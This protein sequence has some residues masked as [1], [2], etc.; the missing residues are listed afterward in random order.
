M[1]LNICLLLFSVEI[2]KVMDNIVWMLL[3]FRVVRSCLNFISD[4]FEKCFFEKILFVFSQGIAGYF[5]KTDS[6]KPTL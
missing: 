3:V 6:K 5:Q 2:Y 1:G 4:L